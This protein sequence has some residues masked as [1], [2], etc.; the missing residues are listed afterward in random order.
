MLQYKRSF[1]TAR[2][3]ITGDRADAI[4]RSVESAISDGRLSAR[5]ALPPVRALAESLGVSPTTVAAAYRTLRQ[6]GLVVGDGRRGTRVASRENDRTRLPIRMLAGTTNLADGNPDPDLL[7][8]LEPLV[9]RLPMPRDL[10][11]EACVLPELAAAGRR[12]LEEDDVDASALSVVSGAMDGIERVLTTQLRPGDRVAVE[13]PAFAGLLDLLSVLALVP[14]PFAV[15]ANG[16]DPEALAR[17]LASGVQAVVVTPR[18]QNPTGAAVSAPRAAELRKV[19]DRHPGVLLVEDDHA[20]A[21]AGAP[22]AS[23]GSRKRQRHAYLRSMAKALGPDV[24]VALLAGSPDI[25]ARVESRQVVGMRWVS[26]LLQRLVVAALADRTVMAAVARSEKEYANRRRAVIDAL[27]SRG[28]A[29]TG[30]TGMNVWIPVR[31]EAASLQALAVAGYT[32]A[33]G[34]RFRLAAAPGLRVTVSR[35]HGGDVDRFAD[36]AAAALL[37]RRS[38][39]TA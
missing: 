28:V 19:L 24:R 30:R 38:A 31:E 2:F 20:A 22:L 15:D 34:E 27:A 29:A 17:V 26:R 4:A 25:V 7:P 23:L 33:P 9:R 10:Y 12:L 37:P 3:S 32:V 14:V 21:V 6:R 16:P 18:A 1:V 5:E 39:A 36:A 13:D 11:G 35:L 8:D